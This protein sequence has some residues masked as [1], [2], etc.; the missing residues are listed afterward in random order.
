MR[1]RRLQLSL[2]EKGG[3]TGD[4]EATTSCSISSP[5]G[6]FSSL[7]LSLC[8]TI[9]QLTTTTTT[10][11]CPKSYL[12][13][14]E[15]RTIYKYSLYKHTKNIFADMFL[16]PVH[17]GSIQIPSGPVRFLPSARPIQLL[18]IPSGGTEFPTFST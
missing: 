12:Y 7:S 5:T 14:Y 16:D 10:S 9:I 13:L 18:R 4:L 15:F 6:G 17:T 2:Y 11:D 3:T 8:T 1:A